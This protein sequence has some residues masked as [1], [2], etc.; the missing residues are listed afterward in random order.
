MPAIHSMTKRLGFVRLRDFGLVLTP[1]GRILS[2]RPAV[3]D[4][5]L[6]GRIV[7][8]QDDDLAAM[9]LDRWSELGRAM[10]QKPAAL[11]AVARPVA[12]RPIAPLTVKP[13]IPV[14]IKP[15]TPQKP[16]AVASEPVVE[17]DDWEWTIAIAR[18][19]AAAEEVELAAAAAQRPSHRRMRA[20]TV[21]PPT[22]GRPMHPTP[23]RPVP[24]AAMAMAKSASEAA[25]SAVKA[26][27][28]DPIKRDSWESTQPLSEF[29]VSDYTSPTNQILRVVKTKESVPTIATPSAFVQSDTIVEAPTPSIARTTPYA[30]IAE[31]IGKTTPIAKVAD[32]IAAARKPPP[33]GIPT[34][35]QPLP[36]VKPIAVKP[37]AVAPNRTFARGISPVTVIPIPKMPRVEASRIAPVVRRTGPSPVVPIP[38]AQPRRFAKGTGPVLPS[39][40]SANKIGD[41]TTPNLSVGDKTLPSLLLPSV[42]R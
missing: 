7:G 11:P 5:G 18:A 1:E 9:E 35:P 40:A 3:L 22:G 15:P 32:P 8:W 39:T 36:V 6:G 21:P 26:T 29:D 31:P 23:A 2:I 25:S 38:P 28:A 13:P 34:P 33:L 16:V 41:E 4:D 27:E 14:S 10:A 37:I 30:K 42:S 20:D 24:A 17:E 19:R 12:V